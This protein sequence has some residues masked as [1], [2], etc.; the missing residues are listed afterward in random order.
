M[1]NSLFRRRRKSM[2]A[3]RPLHARLGSGGGV[4]EPEDRRRSPRIKVMRKAAVMIAG[5]RVTAMVLDV[6]MHGARIA[7]RTP[8]NIG[9]VVGIC[10]E[11]HGQVMQLPM[12]LI[13]DRYN[14]GAFEAGGEFVDLHPAEVVH[15]R[16]FL[17]EVEAL[18]ADEEGGTAE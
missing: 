17:H 2:A 11:A 3:A 1:F 14:N 6:S 16:T 13:W 9:E 4:L 7:T 5:R 8:R 15:L 10:L 18:E 12:R